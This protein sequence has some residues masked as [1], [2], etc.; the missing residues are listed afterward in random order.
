MIT[1]LR[2]ARGHKE[3]H[4]AAQTSRRGLTASD[5]GRPSTLLKAFMG[6]VRARVRPC[7]PLLYARRGGGS[8]HNNGLAEAAFFMRQVNVCWF[9]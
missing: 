7:A 2:C 3:T 9:P 8:A 6:P 1:V 5:L 4:E